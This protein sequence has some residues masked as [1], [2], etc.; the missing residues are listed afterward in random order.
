VST[1]R[2]SDDER[3]FRLLGEFIGMR[4]TTE[5]HEFLGD[6]EDPLFLWGEVRHCAWASAGSLE[7]GRGRDAA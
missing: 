4:L 2:H 7:E 1:R 6:V 3:K 5:G